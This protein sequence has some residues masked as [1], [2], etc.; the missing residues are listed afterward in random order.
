[1]LVLLLPACTPPADSAHYAA[2]LIAADYD[3][4]WAECTAI[5]DSPDRGDCQQ[6]AIMRFSRFEACGTVEAGTWKEECYFAAAEH[7]ARAKDRMGALRVCKLSGFAVSCSQHVLDGLAMDLRDAP[8]GE[9]GA[10]WAALGGEGSGANA[11]LDFWRSWHRVRIAAELPVDAAGCPEK[12]C[13]D[14]ARAELRKH[15]DRGARHPA[16]VEPTAP[17]E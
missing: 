12:T 15:K 11:E 5:R 14:A 4:A 1:M 3:V 17:V 7:L 2:A 9:V 10:A 6:A 8:A 13:R 16:E